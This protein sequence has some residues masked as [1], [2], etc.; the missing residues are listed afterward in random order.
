MNTV[1][2]DIKNAWSRPNNGVIQLIIINVA[3]FIGLFLIR[4][5]FR[6]AGIE[7][8][9]IGSY[10][11]VELQFV[12]FA[13]P[14]EILYR[15]W[16]LLTYA[17]NHAGFFHIFWNM[18]GLFWFGRLFSEYLGSQKLIN[19]YVLGAL[20]GSLIYV[21]VFGVIVK[22]YAGVMVGA[23]AAIYAIVV[24]SAVLMP[25]YRFHLLFLGPVKIMYIAIAFILISLFQ[26]EQGINMG[27]NLAHLAGALIGFIYIKQLNSG[28]EMGRWVFVSMEWIQGLF[29]KRSKIKVSHRSSPFSSSA[30]SRKKQ[31]SSSSSS[32]DVSQEEIDKILDKIADR[33]YD[34]LS[35]EEKQ[36]LFNASKK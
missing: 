24:A 5:I 8:W 12:V 33:G 18:I 26:L 25:E 4:L 20:A 1:I 34:S 10:N 27:G 3:V 15:P 11:Y 2:N 21:I 7:D 14:V 16:T 6:L 17:F 9:G 35:R 19:L 22:G 36:K 23:S 13:D 30:K 28:N 31:S 29:K 32:T